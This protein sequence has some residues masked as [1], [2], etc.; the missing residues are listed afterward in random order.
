MTQVQ[1]SLIVLWKTSILNL[2]QLHPLGRLSAFKFLL[3]LLWHCRILLNIVK[4]VQLEVNQPHHVTLFILNS[5]T[6]LS[7]D[8]LKY[9]R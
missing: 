6:N 9:F 7:S 8:I 4:K 2:A 5:L 3:P 1:R